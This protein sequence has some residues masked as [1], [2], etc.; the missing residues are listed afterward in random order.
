VPATNRPGTNWRSWTAEW[1]LK[2]G[3]G[4]LI[5]GAAAP[6][7]FAPDGQTIAMGIGSRPK[8]GSRMW[9]HVRLALWQF[10]QRE[11][12]RTLTAETD[13]PSAN[14]AAVPEPENNVT[15]AAFQPDG[16]QLATVSDHGLVLIWPIGEEGKPREIANLD[17]QL[18]A[19]RWGGVPATASLTFD[20][21]G[22]TLT[23]AASTIDRKHPDVALASTWQIDLATGK[24]QRTDAKAAEPQPAGVSRAALPGKANGPSWRSPDGKRVAN[25]DATATIRIIDRASG[26]I[27]HTL[28]ADEAAK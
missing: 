19:I 21:E 7:A 24:F 3:K 4:L 8:T 28:G 11:P 23:L 10:G 22:K 1:D 27:V 16:K 9:P 13:K 14:R 5:P 15:A 20:D 26:A 2:T 18:Q 25:V 6:V 12:S 17:Q